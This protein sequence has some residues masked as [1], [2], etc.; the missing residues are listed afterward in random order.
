MITLFSQVVKEQVSKCNMVPTSETF[1]SSSLAKGVIQEEYFFL[2]QLKLTTLFPGIFEEYSNCDSYRECT[3]CSKVSKQARLVASSLLYF[4]CRHLGVVRS[5]FLSTGWRTTC[6]NRTVIFR[7]VLS[8]LT[9]IILVVLGV[10]NLLFR[11]SFVLL[12]AASSL[13][14]G[15]FCLAYSLVIR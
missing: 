4:R 10:L 3:C 14:C 9:S 11:G 6:R 13:N 5:E 8:G 2:A 1:Q 7:L 12:F 15:S